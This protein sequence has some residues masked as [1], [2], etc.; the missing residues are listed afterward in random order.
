MSRSATRSEL[1]AI[2]SVYPSNW[3]ILSA[4]QRMNVISARLEPFER[5]FT[6]L[7]GL[8]LPFTPTSAPIPIACSAIL[9]QEAHHETSAP[10]ILAAGSGRCR[11]AS[12]AA[13]RAGATLPVATGTHHRRL[14]RRWG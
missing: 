7:S 6:V 13:Y 3:N 9:S 11:A 4:E 10:Q 1:R 14:A 5:N 8:R 12:L 2:S